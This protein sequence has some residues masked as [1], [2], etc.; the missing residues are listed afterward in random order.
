MKSQLQ[1]KD[2][3][4]QRDWGLVGRIRV[5]HP[6]FQ[7]FIVRRQVSVHG[8]YRPPSHMHLTLQSILSLSEQL[9]T[10]FPPARACI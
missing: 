10:F 4:P 2:E 5:S 9:H 6:G 7:L 8:L 3:S 1:A